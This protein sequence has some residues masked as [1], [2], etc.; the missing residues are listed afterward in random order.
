MESNSP[1]REHNAWVANAAW[2]KAEDRSVRS[3]FIQPRP[4]PDAG[5]YYQFDELKK[6]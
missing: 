5:V 2:G 6:S 4:N 1:S 3:E